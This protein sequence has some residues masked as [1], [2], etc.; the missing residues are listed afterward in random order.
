M[1]KTTPPDTKKVDVAYEKLKA[2]ITTGQL[3]PGRH[4]YVHGL[5]TQMRIG[6]TPVREALMRLEVEE[7][8]GSTRNRGFYVRRIDPNESIEL[9]DFTSLVLKTSIQ[10]NLRAFSSVT[11]RQPVQDQET[12]MPVDQRQ[13]ARSQGQALEMLYRSI[14]CLGNNRQYVEAIQHFNDR[15]RLIRVV[16]VELAGPSR[17]A[18]D[19][20]R[21]I[22]ALESGHVGKAIVSVQK[23]FAK[24]QRLVPDAVKEILMVSNLS[25]F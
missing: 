6:L 12:R 24:F 15:T 4:L 11:T 2:M 16:S 25:R 3:S 19:T 23:H 5:A 14:A 13:A 9:Y 1:Q 22:A 8:I 18:D 7:L 10:A 20:A 17:I 21:L